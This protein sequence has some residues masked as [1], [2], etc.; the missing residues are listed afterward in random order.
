MIAK[1]LNF[2]NLMK[3]YVYCILIPIIYDNK[4]NIK[5]FKLV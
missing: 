5:I 2:F 3:K 4:L 1:F